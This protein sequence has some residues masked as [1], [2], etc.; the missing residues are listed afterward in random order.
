MYFTQEEIINLSIR[1]AAPLTQEEILGQL[2]QEHRDSMFIAEA[3]DGVDYFRVDNNVILD[4]DFTEWIDS[5]GRK[6]TAY[7]SGVGSG[8]GTLASVQDTTRKADNRLPGGFHRKQLLEKLSYLLKNPIS[9]TFG[10]EEDDKT[11]EKFQ[12]VLGKWFQDEVNEWA[13]FAGNQGNSW[14]H[15]FLDGRT[16]D[17]QVMPTTGIIPIY[18]SSRQRKLDAVIRYYDIVESVAKDTTDIKMKAEWWTGKEVV[19]YEQG[20]GGKFEETSREN[21]FQ[22]VDEQTGDV[23]AGGSW[24]RPPFVELKN[25]NSVVSDLHFIKNLIDAYDMQLSVFSN[26]LEEIKAAIIKAIGTNDNPDSIRD[27]INRFGVVTLEAGI[28]GDAKQDIDFLAMPIPHEAKDALLRKLEENISGTGMALQFDVDNFGSSPTGVALKWLYLPLDLK[29][30]LL[31]VK[32]RKSLH[33]MFW[34]VNKFFEISKDKPIKEDDLVKFEFV[35]DKSMITNEQEAITTANASIGAV[36]E[37]T[38]LVNDP[39]VDDVDAEMERMATER[40]ERQEAAVAAFGGDED[41]DE[42]A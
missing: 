1:Q 11:V 36:S 20:S 2:I 23:L 40:K 32:L 7:G 8:T 6:H 42:D 33:E 22:F 37:E 30:G 21:H 10:D 38:R 17:Y 28:S 4:H 29:A 27:N 16:F 39:R 35:F 5:K 31:E 18:E 15:F 26:D 13:E 24:G 3:F 19:Y 14:M 41:E 12:D 34:F 25:N 9:I